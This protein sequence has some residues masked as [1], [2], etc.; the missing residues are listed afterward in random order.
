MLGS[1]KNFVELSEIK[2][3]EYDDFEDFIRTLKSCG[4]YKQGKVRMDV[5]GLILFFIYTSICGT[6]IW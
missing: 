5:C 6:I 1:V 4:D 3:A 2:S